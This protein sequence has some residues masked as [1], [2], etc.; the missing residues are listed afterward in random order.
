MI[1][2][3]V[4]LNEAF[5]IRKWLRGFFFVFQVVLQGGLNTVQPHASIPHR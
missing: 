1:G 3:G 4:E 2:N 5:Q